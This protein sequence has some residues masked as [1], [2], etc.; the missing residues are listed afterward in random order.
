[1]ECPYGTL[2]SSVA[3]C[4]FL[5]CVAFLLMFGS[6]QRLALG[7]NAPEGQPPIGAVTNPVAAPQAAPAPSALQHGAQVPPAPD[8]NT[9]PWQR[10]KVKRGI[11][12]ERRQVS[13]ARFFEYRVI[14]N[15]P[16]PPLKVLDPLW[17]HATETPSAIK[18]REVLRQTENEILF[19]DQIRAPVVSDRD[20]TMIVHKLV[21]ADG[22]SC[23]LV[24][25]TA[26]HLGPPVQ[27]KLVRI[28]A[29][30]GSWT[31][32]SDGSG[33][34]RLT[35]ITYSDPGGSIP[36][37]FVHGAQADSVIDS[38]LRLQARLRELSA[39]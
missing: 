2:A 9:S 6:L 15:S 29:I 34:S 31:V 20:Y 36:P 28:P 16:V 32:E 27:P 7:E 17:K 26:N 4:F 5:K 13:G 21:A 23:Q 19:Y 24:Y 11:M 25:E 10:Y 18:K 12:V 33:G 39:Q 14:F 38:V 35:S 22:L 1:M 8:S 37:I 3:R 30:R